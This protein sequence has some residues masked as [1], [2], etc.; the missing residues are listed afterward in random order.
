LNEIDGMTF[1][2][3]LIMFVGIWGI[4]LATSKC[5]LDTAPLGQNAE[6]WILRD[7]G[8]LWH[9]NKQYDSVKGTGPQEGD[10]IVRLSLHCIVF[11]KFCY[12]TLES[13][14]VSVRNVLQGV[15]YDH[16]EQRFYLNGRPMNIAF[17][18][19]KGTVFPVLYGTLLKLIV[20]L[21]LT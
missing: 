7:D 18:G 15:S 1:S 19:I 10:V 21:Q 17:S 13:L 2:I 12:F 9:N 14:S 8:T 4:G 3:N 20:Q 11:V 5:S 6:S 16:T